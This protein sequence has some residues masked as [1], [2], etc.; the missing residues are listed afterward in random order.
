VP[1]VPFVFIGRNRDVAWA[2]TP[3]TSIDMEDLFVYNEYNEE[4]EDVVDGGSHVL[5]QSH[6]DDDHH[7]RGGDEHRSAVFSCA[8]SED[9]QERYEEIIVRHETDTIHMHVVDTAHGPIINHLLRVELQSLLHRSYTR[10]HINIALYTQSLQQ[11]ISLQFF[12]KL[13]SASSFLDFQHAAAHL[14]H[15]HVNVLYSD[16]DGNIGSTITGR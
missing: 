2:L 1:G 4:K 6:D 15:L 13:N 9:C 14:K 3:S 11:P 16:V 8:I 5:E 10:H 12:R 7:H